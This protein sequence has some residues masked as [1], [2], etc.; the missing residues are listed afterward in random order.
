MGSEMCIRDS[1]TTVPTQPTRP[2]ETPAPHDQHTVTPLPARANS[3]FRPVEPSPRT[4]PHTGTNGKMQEIPGAPESTEAS[5]KLAHTAVIAPHRPPTPREL[6]GSPFYSPPAPRPQRSREPTPLFMPAP[7]QHIT[8]PV[9]NTDQSAIPQRPS[10]PQR[11]PTQ[12]SSTAHPTSAP[13]VQQEAPIRV[14]P[15][16]LIH[17]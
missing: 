13:T 15:L 5:P 4:V 2:V 12:P 7:Q 6:P 1:T 11:L 16:S 3:A 14:E 8:A 10:S 9:R 17:I